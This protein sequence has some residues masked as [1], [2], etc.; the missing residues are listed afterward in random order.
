M[1]YNFTAHN[2]DDLAFIAQDIMDIIHDNAESNIVLFYGEMGAGKTT[3]IRKMCDAA[4]V[5]DTVTSPTFAIINE[6][7]IP[8]GK[9]IFHFDFYRIESLN[10][11]YDLGYDE[12]FYSGNLCF[13][14]W[15]EKI[16]PILKA[17][18]STLKML[19]ISIRV[20]DNDARDIQ[21]E[22]R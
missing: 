1:K 8:D 13:I 10:E 16:E 22:L 9:T 6:Y 4:Q 5:T 2:L 17:C 19:K 14:E 15:P 12:Y 21:L 18:E 3:L 11:V 20:N 7:E